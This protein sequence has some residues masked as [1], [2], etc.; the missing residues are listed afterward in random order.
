MQTVCFRIKTQSN[1]DDA[2]DEIES[3][4]AIEPLYSSED[5][6]GIKEIYA[7]VERNFEIPTLKH[8]IDYHATDL[9]AIDWEKQ[10]QLHGMDYYD[11][12]V[13]VNLTNFGCKLS[14]RWK[15]LKLKPGPGFGDLS[16]TTTRL[17]LEMMNDVVVDQHVLDI[18]SGSGILALSALAMGA[19]NVFGVDI[20][21]EAI[22]HARNNA[23]LNEMS[24]RVKFGF[25]KDFK[26]PLGLEHLV[27]LMNMI[28]NEQEQAWAS[29]KFIHGLK[30]ECL[31]S[32]ILAEDRELYL[33][34]VAEW[35]WDCVKETESDG[36]LGLHFVRK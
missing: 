18:G 13:H 8:V 31:I 22:E 16:H 33:A 9:E 2:W 19:K 29:L 11:G 12:C 4:S 35:G 17:V 25:A 5:P 6:N 23:N 10:W 36:W 3:F 30:L 26:V 21:S 32:G 27:I 28:Q 1:L 15:D 7:N 20:D 34:K 24:D 14:S